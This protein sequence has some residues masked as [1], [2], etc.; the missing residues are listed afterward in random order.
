MV[1]VALQVE[2]LIG[3]PL[4]ADGYR[5]GT[6]DVIGVFYDIPSAAVLRITPTSITSFELAAS[7]R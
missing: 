2:T 1:N 5:R 3:H 6:L 7:H 4:I